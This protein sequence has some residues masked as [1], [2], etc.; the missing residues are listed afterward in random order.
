MEPKLGYSL[1]VGDTV[2]LRTGGP[3]MTIVRIQ[4]DRAWCDWYDHAK[5]LK[6]AFLIILL[7]RA[8]G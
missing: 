4:G 8:D 6:E 7:E 1:K 5:L 3:K 2:R